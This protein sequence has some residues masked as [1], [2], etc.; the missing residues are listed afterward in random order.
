M[1]TWSNYVAKVSIINSI[2]FLL[3]E[4]NELKSGPL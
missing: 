1:A 2:F 4:E 3:G